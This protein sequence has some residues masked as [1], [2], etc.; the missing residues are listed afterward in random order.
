MT[1]ELGYNFTRRK[2]T[3]EEYDIFMKEN[4]IVTAHV[5]RFAEPSVKF[6]WTEEYPDMSFGRYSVASR[7]Q[8]SLS[9]YYENVED[10]LYL[11]YYELN[12]IINNE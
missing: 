7:V 6:Y 9:P 2:V 12:G 5:I 10:D 3:K 1:K 4:K 11:H 8:K